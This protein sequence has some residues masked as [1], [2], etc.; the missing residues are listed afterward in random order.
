MELG[1]DMEGRATRPITGRR[2]L[3][4]KKVWAPHKKDEEE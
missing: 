2:D 4:K 1:L 3:P